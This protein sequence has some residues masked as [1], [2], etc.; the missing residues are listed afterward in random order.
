MDAER[1]GNH[2]FFATFH[3]DLLIAYRRRAE[4]VV[5]LVFFVIVIS[6]FPIG[7][8][9]L[10]SQLSVIASGVVWVA[11]L[12]SCLL[13]ADTLF[14]TDF[15]DGSL[16]QLL[17][18]LPSLY[19]QAIAKVLVHW[20]VS[21]LPLTL[22]APVLALLLYLPAAATPALILS[23]L[24]GTLTLSFIGGIGAA[25]TV[26]LRKGGLLLALLIL[27]LFVPI[28][29]FG[30]AAVDAAAQGNNY[31]GHLAILGALA[32]LAVAL[33]PLAIAAALRISVDY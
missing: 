4:L 22:L 16:E 29:I 8:S 24:L 31:M 25:L 19:M 9:P 28:L 17:L 15:D 1:M 6:L 21:G 7:V 26:G 3:R 5:P 20:L 30:T 13:A 2:A 12:L 23:L 18:G 11:A 14:R 27:P 10:P 32:L 33:A